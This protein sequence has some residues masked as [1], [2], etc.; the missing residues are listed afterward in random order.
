VRGKP[1]ARGN[2]PRFG[3]GMSLAFEFTG[4]VLLFWFLGRLIDTRFDTEPWGQVVGAVIGW[5]GGFLHVYYK[6]KGA[7]WETV[8]GTRRPAQKPTQDRNAT[9]K[10]ETREGEGQ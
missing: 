5:V 7:G 6:T 4:A 8:P 2:A 9:E 3:Q 10:T 1:G